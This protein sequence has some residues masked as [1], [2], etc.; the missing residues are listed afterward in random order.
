MGRFMNTAT[1]VGGGHLN[2]VLLPCAVVRSGPQVLLA[3][4]R[5]AGRGLVEP[6]SG[7][8]LTWRCADGVVE[9]LLLTGPTAEVDRDLL[10][11]EFAG[12]G[13]LIAEVPPGAELGSE[14]IAQQEPD[15]WILMPRLS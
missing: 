7:Q 8:P 15:F 13:L 12:G 10:V 14:A 2:S 4:E 6:I 9:S 1:S 5:R 3:L 11:R